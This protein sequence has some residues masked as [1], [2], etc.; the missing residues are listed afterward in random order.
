MSNYFIFQD[1][2]HKKTP[3]NIVYQ[4]QYITAFED[5]KPKAPIHILIVPNIFIAS[6]NDIN[7]EN[8]NIL[9][10]M[11]Y[12]AINIAKNKNIHQTGY[13][14]IVNCNKHGGQEI[15]YLHMHLLGGKKLSKL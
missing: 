8:K 13:R 14:I 1:I 12:V 3:S 9:A 5:I 2:I 4:D 15:D 6:S 11:F 10:D 7:I